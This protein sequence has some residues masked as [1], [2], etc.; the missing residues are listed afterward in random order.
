MK[1][2][3]DIADEDI[4][5]LEKLHGLINEVLRVRNPALSPMMR[6]AKKDHYIMDLF[7]KKGEQFS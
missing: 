6:I 1:P 3:G 4:K 5:R 2:E 7:V